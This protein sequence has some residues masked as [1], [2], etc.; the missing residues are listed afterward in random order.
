M[1]IAEKLICWSIVVRVCELIDQDLSKYNNLQLIQTLLKT[2]DDISNTLREN[3]NAYENSDL[4]KLNNLNV[5]LDLLN[6]LAS[7][8]IDDTLL[9]ADSIK[10]FGNL[11]G[12]N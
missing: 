6:Q 12:D 1:T 10:N 5:P 11:L 4:N 7:I 2:R 8:L 9:D 3:I